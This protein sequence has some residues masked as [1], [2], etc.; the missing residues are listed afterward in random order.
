[1]LVNHDQNQIV[2]IHVCY[3]CW[4]YYDGGPT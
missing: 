4:F 3:C 2:R 1:L